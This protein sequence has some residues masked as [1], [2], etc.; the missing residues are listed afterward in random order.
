MLRNKELQRFAALFAA[1]CAAAAAVG[2]AICAAAGI[3]VCVLA[4]ALGA[5][6]FVFTK[7]RYQSLARLSEQIDAVLHNA[8]RLYIA[9]ADEGE[10]SIL[11]SEITKMT[12]RVREQNAALIK[13]KE[14]LADS[15]ADV[16]HQ[17]RTPLTSV[18]LILS[19]LENSREDGERRALALEAQA[20]LQRTDWLITSLLKLSRLDAGVAVFQ[21]EKLD[22]GR[23][24]RDALR[25]LLIPMELHQIDARLNAPDGITLWGDAGWLAEALGNIL[26]N[27]MESAGDGGR[28]EIACSDN[29][30]F[31]EITIRDSGAGFAPQ[32]LP[33]LFERFYRG[34]NASAAGF[35]VGLA[36]SRAIITRQGG[37][38]AAK[39]HPQGGALF[40]IRFAKS[41]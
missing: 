15:L 16:A 4:A 11:E 2:F 6:F 31:T 41:E 29:P 40:V 17:L 19:R 35:G 14:R 38:L 33:R 39:N 3:L 20:L 25:P 36:L 26:K 24:L 8:D 12:L 34:G 1:L 30:L 22:A 23:L 13:E 9:D 21:R 18:S 7:A 5:A 27:C 10:L 37:T 32:D 28:V